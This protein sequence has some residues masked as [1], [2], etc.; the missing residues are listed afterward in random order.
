MV[1]FR[2]FEIIK[3][4]EQRNNSIPISFVGIFPNERGKPYFVLPQGFES[5]DEQNLNNFFIDLY[6]V[7]KKYTNLLENKI[8]QNKD[9]NIKK[10]ENGKYSINNSSDTTIYYSKL[11]NIDN[12]LNI[13]EGQ[14]FINFNTKLAPMKPFQIKDKHLESAIYQNDTIVIN[15][16]IDN[17]K[18]IS[19][20]SSIDILDMLIFIYSQINIELKEKEKNIKYKSFYD[21]FI[22][23]FKF[24]NNDNIFGVTSKNTIEKLKETLEIINKN[25]SYKDN[26]YYDIYDSIEEFL[27][28][29]KMI[30]SRKIMWGIDSFS[31]IW[32]DMYLNFIFENINTSNILFADSLR[33]GNT[34]FPFGNTNKSYYTYNEDSKSYPFYLK[35]PKKLEKYLYPDIVIL[36]RTELNDKSF[37]DFFDIEKKHY[38]SNIN[39]YIKL[40]PKYLNNEYLKKVFIVDQLDTNEYTIVEKG[41]LKRIND[42]YNGE[43][44]RDMSR[45]KSNIIKQL[46]SLKGQVEQNK[47]Y[48]EIFYQRFIQII[49]VKYYSKEFLES[50]SKKVQNDSI[51]QLVY[52]L[53]LK[54]DKK[55]KELEVSNYFI[56]P[57]YIDIMDETYEKTLINNSFISEKDITI[58]FANFQ[59]IMK[60]YIGDI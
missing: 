50:N 44:D 7:F 25:T 10:I 12:I 2:D 27:Y 3:L 53:A 8:K 13:V 19:Q 6:K 38:K 4:P 30:N 49:D 54:Q 26:I 48:D 46:N 42:S 23:K 1:N 37:D 17:K 21:N 22:E 14:T 51:K 36:N 32:E 47:Y 16:V 29:N 5:F 18:F 31:F 35:T 9:Q 40:K 43:W 60:K 28:F 56:I 58:Y 57:K 33:Y 11:D 20:Q 34:Y 45:T 52:E 59:I 39:N 15:E 55:Y 41:Y 24:N